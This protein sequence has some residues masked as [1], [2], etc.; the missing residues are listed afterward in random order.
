MQIRRRLAEPAE[1]KRGDNSHFQSHILALH[2]QLID[3]IWTFFETR[4][5]HLSESVL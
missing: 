4:V 1:K 3:F 2:F 5:S